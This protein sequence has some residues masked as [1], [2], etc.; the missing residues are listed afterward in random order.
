MPSLRLTSLIALGA[1]SLG[2]CALGD[3]PPTEEAAQR[4]AAASDATAVPDR[5]TPPTTIEAESFELVTVS[6]AGEVCLFPD[7]PPADGPILDAGER[8]GIEVELPTCLSSTCDVERV[9]SCTVTPLGNL[10]VVEADFS[11]VEFQGDMCT[12]DCVP[13]T[14][15]CASPPLAAGDYEVVFSGESTDVAVPSA[16]ASCPIL[17]EEEP[18]CVTDAD[19]PEGWCGENVDG[20][21]TCHEWSEEGEPCGGFAPVGLAPRCA[22]ALTC[23]ELDGPPDLP[24]RCEYVEQELIVEP[25]AL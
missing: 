2:A 10:L 3:A 7:T 13:L 21:A 5:A 14:A 8:L 9:A 20:V 16:V 24:G 4:F 25:Y 22:P 1:W 18:E 17:V 19:C 15:T 6:D 12:L 11:Y 23:V